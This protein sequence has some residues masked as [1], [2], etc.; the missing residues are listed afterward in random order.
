[1]KAFFRDRH[2]FWGFP[3]SIGIDSILSIFTMELQTYVP[4]KDHGSQDS[5]SVGVVSGAQM[6]RRAGSC[7]AGPSCLNLSSLTLSEGHPSGSQLSSFNKSSTDAHSTSQTSMTKRG[8]GSIETRRASTSLSTMAE[9]TDHTNSN[10]WAH[11][12]NHGNP[13]SNNDKD[14]WGY[15]VDVA[16]EDEDED[17]LM[18]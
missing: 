7:S 11:S 14:A 13:S 5:L 17:A 6:M 4:L 1:M 9:S 18:W 3:F 12:L 8:W 2:S 16:G 10:S 15:F